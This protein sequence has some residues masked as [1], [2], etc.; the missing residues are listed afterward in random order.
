[1]A[2]TSRIQRGRF[3]MAEARFRS[4]G[5]HRYL[6]HTLCLDLSSAG[7]RY[8]QRLPADMSLMRHH[9][10]L[11]EFLDEINL[12]CRAVEGHRNNDR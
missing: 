11:Q 8:T 12:F 6:L 7:P 9:I 10:L 4:S 1:V 3:S 2:K 5:L